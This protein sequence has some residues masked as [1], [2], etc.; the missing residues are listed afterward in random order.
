[1]QKRAVVRP[2]RGGGAFEIYYDEGAHLGGGDQAPSPL[3]Y[4][5]AGIAF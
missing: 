2:A 5:S 3:A 1:M 4:F